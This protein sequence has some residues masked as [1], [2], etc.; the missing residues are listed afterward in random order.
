[1]HN[2]NLI[3]TPGES[4]DDII[5][6]ICHQ[7]SI[8]CDDY[9]AF[10]A[11]M[12]D[13]N[14]L[15]INCLDEKSDNPYSPKSLVLKLFE[16]ENETR[17][18]SPPLDQYMSV[19]RP[20]L[21]RMVNRAYDIYR[22]LIPEK[23]ELMCILNLTIVKLYNK[24]YYLHNYLIY[25]SFINQLNLEIRK[26]KLFGDV[27]SLDS[28]MGNGEEGTTLTLM[29][30]LVNQESSD[31]AYAQMHY[32]KDDWREDMFESIKFAMLQDMSQLQFDRILIQLK[33]NTVDSCTSK[34]LARYREEFNP[35]YSPRPNAKGRKKI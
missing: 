12:T 10:S 6:K 14:K 17:Y 34:K 18:A 19:F 20:N 1:M 13:K 25:K 9:F 22:R 26:T 7:E 5:E 31:E 16:Q 23:E 24:G 28:E 11:V 35:G 32:T 33:S 4:I 27:I 3:V 29:D 2:V 30:K 21:L 15:R 8:G